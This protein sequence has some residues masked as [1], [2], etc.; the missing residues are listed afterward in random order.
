MKTLEAGHFGRAALV[1]GAVALM[2]ACGGG[3]TTSTTTTGH[4]GGSAGSG[5]GGSGATAGTGGDIFTTSTGGAGGQGDPCAG[6]DCPPDQHCEVEGG[7]PGCVNN[8]CAT[9]SCGPTEECQATPGGGAQCVDIGCNTDVDCLPSEFCNGTIC[10]DDVCVPGSTSC[11]GAAVWECASNGGGTTLKVTCG[12][13]AYYE[14]LC[15]DNLVGFAYCGCTDDWDCPQ[16]T[17]CASGQCQGTGKPPTCFLSPEPFA[18]VVPT[19]E[20]VWGGTQ[21][22]HTLP[23]S[24][25][26]SSAQVMMAPIVANLDDDNGDGLINELDVPEIIFMT[27][28]GAAYT[29]DGVLRSIHGGGPNKGGDHFATCGSLT[30]HEGDPLPLDCPCSS[31]QLYSGAGLAAGDLDGDGTPEIIA[32]IE[33]NAGFQIFSNKGD[34]IST[35]TTPDLGTYPHPALVNLDGKGFAEI[36]MGRFVFSV[37]HDA[38]G[39]LV[40]QD[41]WAGPLTNSRLSCVSDLDGDGRPDIV[42]G[43]AAYRFPRAPAGA[44]KRADCTGSEVDPDEVAWCTGTLPVLWNAATLPGGMPANAGYCAIADVLGAD[45]TTAPGPANPLDGVPEV[46]IVNGGQLYILE[47]PTGVT[48]RTLPTGESGGGAPNI[49]DFDGDGFPEIGSAYSAGYIMFDLQDP[50]ADC[51]AWPSKP[52]SDSALQTSVNPQRNPPSTSCVVASDCD[53]LVAGT[54]CNQRTHQCVCLHN[55]WRRLT[56]DNSSQITGSTVFDFNGD[57]AAEVVYNDECRFRIYDGTDGTVYMAQPNESGTLLEYPVIAD[58]DNDG[59]AEIV[60][61]AN[62]YSSACSEDPGNTNP[63]HLN[64]LQVWGDANDLWVPARRIWN[65]HAYHVTNVTESGAIP[66]HEPEHWKD[67]NGRKYNIY[68]SNPRTSGVAPDLTVVAVQFT[69]P[70]AGC[71]TLSSDVTITAEIKNQG[72]VRVGPGV[73]LGFHGEWLG[74]SLQEPLYADPLMTPLVV[75]LGSAIEPGASVFVSVQYSALDNSPMT[76]PDNITLV[77]DETAAERECDETNNSITVP[78]KG[79]D[80]APDLRVELGTP[81]K[82]PVCPSLPTTVYNDGTGPATGVVVRFYA[83]NPSQGG[84]ALH[85]ELLPGTLTPG[86]QVSFNATI[87]SFPEGLDIEVWAVVDPAKVIKECNDGN[88]DDA[89]D[90]RITC[91]GIQ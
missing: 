22:V 14:S 63:Q 9:L 62:N 64:G 74:A 86:Q 42:S 34:V 73:V 39:K 46:V 2:S 32:P 3:L 27:Y 17:S 70:D 18:N 52:A 19:P 28:C 68:R 89:A 21:A 20:I 76:L 90:A 11:V 45:P 57:G 43:S 83:G 24:A 26:P 5:A 50:T 65:Q 59:N 71:G 48:R 77:V 75:V 78:V 33:A 8:T 72:D 82:T 7:F 79:G 47:G 55:G 56:E 38:N 6:F 23:N 41:T 30:W 13:A 87:P 51:P 36:V 1:G 88:N 61:I 10:V 60:F 80:Q 58:V 4:E 54:T 15:V 12:S 49:D 69:S 40:L 53:T 91:G 81:S 84:Y 16:N 29:T 44:M 35:A 85:D 67:W 37:A 31:A 66:L 25:F